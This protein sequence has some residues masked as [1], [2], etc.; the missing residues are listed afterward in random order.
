ME[1][2]NKI[3]VI[4]DALIGSVN[5]SEEVLQERLD[6]C[7]GCEYNSANVKVKN[8]KTKVKDS[9]YLGK[10]HCTIC[11]CIID[12][13]VTQAEEYCAKYDKGEVPLWNALQITTN[14][15]VD[16]NI[17]NLTPKAGNLVLDEGNYVLDFG[18]INVDT[19]EEVVLPTMTGKP[20]IK[21]MLNVDLQF[22]V[23]NEVYPIQINAVEATCGCTTPEWEKKDNTTYKLD[24]GLILDVAGVDR[25]RKNINIRY[26]Q[27]NINGSF[28][29]GTNNK[30]LMKA[31]Q[32]ALRGNIKR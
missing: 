26:Y 24:V 9:L 5:V 18:T 31:V 17:V 22:L 7:N 21:K 1:K 29:L 15:T 13:K 20:F 28:I 12:A 2:K 32:L 30:P 19:L 16:L 8:L 4:K 23:V 6:A 3:S 27:K 25:F 10:P 11:S 14:K